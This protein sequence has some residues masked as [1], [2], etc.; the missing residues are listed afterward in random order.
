MPKRNDIKKILIIGSGPIIIGQACEFDYSGAQACKSLKQE[1][2]EV[3]LVNS[4]PATIMT[5]PQIADATYIEPLTVDILEKIIIKERPNAVLPT[6][7]GQT[8][9]NLALQTAKAGVFD[10]YNVEMLGADEETITKAEDRQT[11]KNL[12]IELGLDVPK[13]F[14]VYTIEEGLEKVKSIGYPCVI[15]PAF[16]LGGTGGGIAYNE[17]EFTEIAS[18]GLDK[19]MISEILIEESIIGW[20][21]Y[22]LEVMRDY[23]DN[24][25]IICSIEN[26]DPMGVHTGDSITVAPAQTLT[27]LE[28]Q[29]M[30]EAAINIM[31]KVGVE[32]GGCNVQFAINPKD[33][34][35]VVIE[36]NPR[37]SRSSALASKATGFPIAK[38]A[39]KLA[40]GYSLDELLNDITKKTPACF[41]PALD[42]VVVKI[43]RFNFKKF[44]KTP[45]KLGTTMKSVGEAMSIGRTFKEALQKGI[46]SL[47]VNRFGIGFFGKK[48]LT[49]T[50]ES[51]L[52][53][54][55]ATPNPW[56]LYY[57]KQA[58]VQGWSVDKIHEH[59]HIDPWFLNQIK[60]I[61]DFAQVL[62]LNPA[63][64]RKAK[65]WGFSDVQ[66]GFITNNSIQ[67]I[68]SFRKK[69]HIN[70]TYNLVDTC[71]AEFEAETPYYYSTYETESEITIS[72]NKKIMILGAGPNRIGQGIEFDYCC[73]HASLALRELNFESIMVNS[74]PETVS[75]DFDISDKLYFEPLTFEDV[76]SIYELEKPLG[77]IIQFGGQTPLNLAYQLEKAGVNI[78]GT[79]PSSIADAE[80]REKFQQILI[81]LNLKQPN[82]GI[83]TDN[84]SAIEIANKLNYPVV[85]RPSFVLG[86]ASMDIV[87]N[88]EQLAG[89]IGKAKIINDEHPILIDK[90]LDHAKELDVDALSDGIDC[91]I[92]GIMEHIEPAGVHSGD[93]A[94]VLP[95]ISVS[96][97]LINEIK[98]ATS[99]LAKKLKVIGLLNIQFAIKNDELYI[100]EVNPRGSRTVP[101]VSKATGIAWAKLATQIITG[102]TIKELQIK[103]FTPTYFSVKEAVLPFNK[104][105][106]SDILLSP[107]MK[108]TGETMGI[109]SSYPLAFYKSQVAAGL[110]FPKSGKAFVS[111]GD[112]DKEAFIPIAKSMVEIGFTLIST[113]GTAHFLKEHNIHSIPVGKISEGGTSILDYFNQNEIH[114]VFNTPSDKVSNKDEILIRQQL[115]N[116]QIPY[117]TTI[118]SMSHVVNSIQAY[119][120]S[121]LSVK[122][123]Q[124]FY[125]S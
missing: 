75:T 59:S 36:V 89:Y 47:E 6:L 11:F 31:R 105:P 7:G 65:Q 96:D 117:S 123:L 119:I 112:K 108:S 61:V 99:L 4:N 97:K 15:R 35:L 16:T 3:V 22:E 30:R 122:P 90:Y 81:D 70:T 56:R 106:Q 82:N 86:G 26:L 12:I 63:D 95:A 115:I 66:L 32:T 110:T 83:A 71:A 114:L 38:F 54:F 116:H 77:V 103:E 121:D 29:H 49:T 88:D 14:V 58:M 53:S 124:E 74:N 111:I 51:E 40:V 125:I 84:K 55:I 39:A 109:D 79:S 1:G 19:S 72:D 64:I 28:Y 94:C 43:P 73:V 8:G 27:D 52:T 76:L 17:E 50:A 25:V 37:V 20:K 100:I 67:D 87:Y 18:G 102:K 69:H 68:R 57:I 107:E 23:Q 34:R 41:E 2:Y 24:V 91:V 60:Q 44:P 62:Q 45:P 118:Q 98:T 13:S 120:K 10:K 5:D 9:L 42:Y 113:E 48:D 33:G 93:S 104:F 101:F 46:R 78:L 80:D 92:A 85:I 21:E